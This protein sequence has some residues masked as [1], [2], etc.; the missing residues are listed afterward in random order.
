MER[1]H[2]DPHRG[3]LKD[4]TLAMQA[5][6]AGPVTEHTLTLEISRPRGGIWVPMSSHSSLV[7]LS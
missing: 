3:E 4:G 5:L 1:A 2:S 7:G 6:T